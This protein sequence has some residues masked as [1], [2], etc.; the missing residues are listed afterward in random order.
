MAMARQKARQLLSR[1]PHHAYRRQSRPHQIADRLVGR[2]WNPYRREFAR[3][4]QLGQV[5]AVSSVGL[6]PIAG[7]ARNQRRRHHHAF[8]S[9]IAQL[10]LDAI[11][12]RAGFVA[13]PQLTAVSRQLAAQRL[14]RRPRV[15]DLPVIPNFASLA[16]FRQQNRDGVFVCI[17]AD[18]DDMVLHNPSPMHEAGAESSSATLVVLHIASSHGPPTVP[19]D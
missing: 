15:R 1:L 4:V 6:D 17:K 11:T 13:K 5:D 7:F 8:M 18:V 10:A 19:L 9:V 16:P 14:Q 2:V 3:P 12:A